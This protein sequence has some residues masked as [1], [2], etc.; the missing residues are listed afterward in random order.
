M[1][2]NPF[3]WHLLD[4]RRRKWEGKSKIGHMGMGCEDEMGL[5]HSSC[6]EMSG[7]ITREVD[8]KFLQAVS[9]CTL[10]PVL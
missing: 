10:L 6:M 5:A 4:R 9:C 1:V 8:T 7:S 3:I 2:G